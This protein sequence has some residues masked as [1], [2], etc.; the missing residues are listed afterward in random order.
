MLP[1]HCKNQAISGK[2]NSVESA[3]KYFGLIN[4]FY[5]VWGI[6]F[7]KKD[8]SLMRNFI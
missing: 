4:S 3:Y 2:K 7:E 5:G 8:I 6:N 1:M